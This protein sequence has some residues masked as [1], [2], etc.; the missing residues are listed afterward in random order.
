MNNQELVE[1]LLRQN[2]LAV[3]SAKY[4]KKNMRY[5]SGNNVLK[6]LLRNMEEAEEQHKDDMCAYKENSQIAE[7]NNVIFVTRDCDILNCISLRKYKPGTIIEVRIGNIVSRFTLTTENRYEMF[8]PIMNKLPVFLASLDYQEVIITSPNTQLD[9][10]VY[11]YGTCIS[12]NRRNQMRAM[13]NKI[14]VSL[15]DNNNFIYLDG[16]ANIE[17]KQ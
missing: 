14:T 16:C 10:P 13:N 7:N 9:K 2:K 6:V 4:N 11:F 1:T 8:L 3:H 5:G 17:A 12:S 15:D